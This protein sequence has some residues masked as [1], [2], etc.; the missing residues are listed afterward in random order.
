MKLKHANHSA[1]MKPRDETEPH[2]RSNCS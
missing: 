2:D 1:R